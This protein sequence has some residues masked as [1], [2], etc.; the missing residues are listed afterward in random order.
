MGVDEMTLSISPVAIRRN[1]LG[2]YFGSEQVAREI[3]EAN[4]LIPMRK[5]KGLTLFDICDCARAWVDYKSYIA[6]RDS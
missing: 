4:L 1:Q 5:S 3:I 6:R 2:E